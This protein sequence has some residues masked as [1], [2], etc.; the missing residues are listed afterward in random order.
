LNDRNG[1]RLSEVV[2]YAS[3][4]G[5]LGVLRVLSR[6]RG[7]ILLPIIGRGLGTAAYGAWTQS[8]AAVAVGSSIVLLQFDAALVRFC[9]GAQDRAQQRDIYLP[10]LTIV[11]VLGIVVAIA[12]MFLARPLADIV[13]GDAAFEPIARWLGVWAALTAVG[14]LATQLQRGL[15]RV[16]LFG[17]LGTAE[18][19]GQLVIVA[20]VILIKSDLLL[21]VW[22]AVAWE[23]AYAVAVL[24]L[25]FRSVG[26]GRPRFGTLRRSLNFSLPLVPSYYAGTVLQ[27]ADR[28]F[29]AAQ[30][31][32][33]AVGIYAAAYSL[34]RII[35]EISIPIRT[36]LFPAVSRAWDSGDRS[37]GRWLLSNSLLYYM[38]LAIPALAGLSLLGPQILGLLVGTGFAP[39]IGSIIALLG[40][41][42]IFSCAQSTF[43]M[44]LQLVEDTGALAIS[45]GI[46]AIAYVLF[47]VVGVLKWGLLGG[48]I[49]TAAGYV[50]DM[51]LANVFAWRHDRFDFLW[52][53]TLK[54]AVAT[55]GMS[56][57]VWLVAHPGLTGLG[58]SVVIGVLVYGVLMVALGGVGRRELRFVSSVLRHRTPEPR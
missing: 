37:Q 52:V 21:A 22:G 47:V 12:G 31:G 49:A 23:L 6:L 30:M 15:L 13:L 17:F 48:A 27:F 43:A 57:A 40:I 5:V 18:T 51:A 50:L 32:A 2:T 53:P 58:L 11:V 42:Y 34:A 54:A 16:K 45:R 26:I 7:L 19:L 10:L 56:A 33:E 38:L 4:I 24:I 9:S 55:A 41:A 46:A 3:D 36:A 8:L 28:L 20:G 14:A 29:I 25:A 44:L 1:R 35:S 39:G